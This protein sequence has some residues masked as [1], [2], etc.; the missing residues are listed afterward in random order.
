MTQQVD[1]LKVLPPPEKRY[2]KWWL[3]VLLEVLF[4]A[5]LFI[6]YISMRVASTDNEQLH[7]KLNK[8]QQVAAKRLIDI[9]KELGI[10][11]DDV[12]VN[13]QAQ[14][15]A[16]E[17]NRKSGLISILKQKRAQNIKGFSH[18]LRALSS[19]IVPGVWLTNVNISEGGQLIDLLGKSDDGKLVIEFANKLNADKV[20]EDEKFKVAKLSKIADSNRYEFE[21]KTMLNEEDD[22]DEA[23]S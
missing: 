10:K 17:I 1:F 23:S 5:A 20:F 7:L 12:D 18:Y 2:L 15:L 21:L 19:E 11:G 6:I 8:Q 22:E 16:Q 3:W 13:Q 14:Q 4:V 9:E